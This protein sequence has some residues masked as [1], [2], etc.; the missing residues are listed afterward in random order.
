ME[1]GNVRNIETEMVTGLSKIE[2]E[3]TPKH[4]E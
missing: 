4:D 2:E 3:V 1:T